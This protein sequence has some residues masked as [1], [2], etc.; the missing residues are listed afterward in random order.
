M[1]SANAN[2]AEVLL[3]QRGSTPV[4]ISTAIDAA[5]AAHREGTWR[6]LPAD[7]RAEQLL[8]IADAIEELIDDIAMVDAVSTVFPLRTLAPWRASV[9]PHFAQLR[10]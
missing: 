5:V 10:S 8:R 3:R 4:Q 1:T 6:R 9:G 2:T 7:K